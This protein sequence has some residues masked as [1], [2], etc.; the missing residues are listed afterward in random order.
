[1]W[2]GLVYDSSRSSLVVWSGL[3]W[4]VLVCSGLFWSGLVW[5]G[6]VWSGLVW[7]GLVWSGL[8][9]SGL[10]WSGLV[11]SGLVWSGLVW[12]GLSLILEMA[13]TEFCPCFGAFV[14]VKATGHALTC[15]KEVFKCVFGETIQGEDIQDKEDAQDVPDRTW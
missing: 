3:V 8:V 12:S 6:L 5:S 15:A 1:M 9:W 4:S 7:S 13:G 2:Y 10:V 14:Q 11:W